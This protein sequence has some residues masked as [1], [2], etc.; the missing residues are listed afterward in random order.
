MHSE[1]DRLSSANLEQRVLQIGVRNL[2]D[3]DLLEC[4][5]FVPGFEDNEMEFQITMMV[6]HAKDELMR[7][8]RQKEARK[9]RRFSMFMA[10]IA[11]AS[12]SV[13]T[14]AVFVLKKLDPAQARLIDQLVQRLELPADDQ[15]LAEADS[16]QV[17]PTL[18][19]LPIRS[20]VPAANP[21]E[22]APRPVGRPKEFR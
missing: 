16:E 13:A 6:S 20:P 3:K 5:T 15:P 10:L 7:R 19:E 11:V 1:S 17:P 14:Y 4:A 22:S 21:G 12:A 9:A 2:N 18:L 8:D